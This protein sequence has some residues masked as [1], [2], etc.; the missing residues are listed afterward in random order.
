MLKRLKAIR[1]TVSKAMEASMSGSGPTPE[2][3][4]QLP[5][6]Q[7]AA[8][9]AA[10]A[11]VEANQRQLDEFYQA[12]A[13]ALPL[14]GPAGAALNPPDPRA[15][16]QAI[17][18]ALAEGG[19]GAYLKASWTGTAPPKPPAAPPRAADPAAQAR[20]EWEAR[21]AARAPY[22]APDRAPVQISRIPAQVHSQFQQVT[23]HL[24]STGLS[25]R[26]D[27]V[28]GLYQVPDHI[29]H[30]LGRSK[31]RYIEWDIVHAATGPLTPAGPPSSTFLPADFT[32]VARAS[33]EPSVLD[34][35]LGI[36]LLSLAGMGPDQ[37]LGVTRVVRSIVEDQEDSAGRTLISVM[38]TAVFGRAGVS[39]GVRD[40]LA[41]AAP[42]ALPLGAPAGVVTE[43]LNW[44]AV[45]AAVHPNSQGPAPIPSPFS[46]L[47]GTAQELLIA[48]IQIVGINPIDCYGAS[49]TEDETRNLRTTR[50]S[51]GF[52]VSSNTSASTPCVDGKNRM[53]MFGGSLVVVSYR[54][55]PAYQEGRER[56][57][58]YQ[59][60]V[61]QAHL[62]RGTGA[63]RPVIPMA[64]GS[65][66]RSMR[67]VINAAEWT[68]DAIDTLSGD[69]TSSTN[70]ANPHRY[71]WPP[72]DIT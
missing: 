36:T 22:L 50:Q 69:W 33:G 41:S 27:L 31:S 45:A 42:M 53:R 65:L 30:D 70:K 21:E 68:L 66:P 1:E 7:R 62:E 25:A 32:W 49:V 20:L 34:E 46:Y 52:S 54:D 14:Q 26:P 4:D 61:L 48:Y 17:Q 11:E 51:Y 8:Y 40:R 44:G 39:D 2:Q 29:G 47:P 19:L 10:L 43:V 56:W 16:S 15:T 28:F 57:A 67:K 37:S 72:T 6:E 18:Q 13:D 12:Q 3:L 63:R 35:D 64:W 5:P 71:C 38:G 59:R 60:D 58:A 9:E 23:T 55:R 24:A